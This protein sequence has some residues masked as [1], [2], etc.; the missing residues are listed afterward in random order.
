M[1]HLAVCQYGSHPMGQILVAY[2]ANIL[3]QSGYD[4]TIG[5]LSRATGLPKSSISRYVAWQI[6]HDYAEEII[7]PNDR[8]LR[9]LKQT[10]KGRIEMRVMLQELADAFSHID[11][12]IKRIGTGVAGDP[13]KILS[14][15]EELTKASGPRRI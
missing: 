13:E 1:L 6:A 9:R 2:T 11:Q 10:K 3:H 7:D 14:R 12:V 8:R 5:D 4:P 15:M